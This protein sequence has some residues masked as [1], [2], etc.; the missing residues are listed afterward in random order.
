M[1]RCLFIAAAFALIAAPLGSAI[2]TRPSVLV[3]RK[4]DLP[5]GYTVLRANTGRLSNVDAA[6]G[7][8]H[9]LRDFALWGRRDGYSIEYDG[10]IRGNIASRVDLFRGTAGAG[11]F[12]AWVAKQT[13]SSAGIPLVRR[14][15]GLGD[16][17]YVFRK[18]FGSSIFVIVEWRYRNVSAH[19]SADS[20]GI[21]RT[22][23]LARI[24]QRRIAA[25]LH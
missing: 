24:Q 20:V 14:Q 25:A 6:Q 23:A 17:A 8:R 2:V 3:L 10:G 16:A 4:S 13:P 12:L 11:N 5:A 1:R 18:D 7:N 15:S 9:L 19:V 22:L 21:R